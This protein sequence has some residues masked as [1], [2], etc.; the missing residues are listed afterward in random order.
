[1][2]FEQATVVGPSFKLPQAPTTNGKL[3]SNTTVSPHPEKV[4][5]LESIKF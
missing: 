2:I 5:I 1:M 3:F 4:N